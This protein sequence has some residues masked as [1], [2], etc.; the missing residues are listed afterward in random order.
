MLRQN[1]NAAAHVDGWVW[2]QRLSVIGLFVLASG[3]ALYVL[4]QVVVPLVLAW[5]VATIFLPLVHWLTRRG[6]NHVVA[7]LLI[8]LAALLV[9]LLA[10]GLLS[11]PLAG[12]I[13]RAD[14]IGPTLKAKIHLL[15][16]PLAFLNEFARS[17]QEATGGAGQAP[18]IDTSS[19]TIARGIFDTLSPIVSEFL[20][21]FIAFV[22]NLIYS[23]DIIGGI[24]HLFEG[25]DI[26]DMVAVTLHDIEKNMSAYFGTCAIINFCIGAVTTAMVYL[27]GYPQPLLWGAFAMIMNFIPYLGPALVIGTLFII[28]LLAFDTISQAF[29]A[30][31]IYVGI[32]TIEGQLVTPL[33]IGH[34]LTINPFLIFVAIAF[35]SFL[36][37]PIGAFL[38]VPLVL[39][40]LVAIRRM[41][42]RHDGVALSDDAEEVSPNC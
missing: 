31:L 23:R 6:V 16:E 34:R 18:T 33:L 19:A 12:W 41:R 20:L 30:P 14:Q 28:G 25:S 9:I 13:S 7:A 4:R 27:V 26:S 42:S 36:W 17:L 35:L 2:A 32:T 5:V 3:L 21:F 40:S 37:G 10:I 11:L 22:F 39:T 29:V 8:A 24:A 15:S 38:A 1:P